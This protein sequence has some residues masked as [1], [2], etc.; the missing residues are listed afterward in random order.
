M[1]HYCASFCR[2]SQPKV[3]PSIVAAPPQKDT[4]TTEDSTSQKDESFHTPVAKESMLSASLRAGAFDANAKG[5][6]TCSMPDLR[7]LFTSSPQAEPPTADKEAAPP[8]HETNEDSSKEEED[9]S[10]EEEELVNKFVE[11]SG[12]QSREDEEGEPEEESWSSSDEEDIHQ[13]VQT[14]QSYV[15]E[16]SML[17]ILILN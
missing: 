8:N 6:L 17:S 7:S 4:P 11:E 15:D 1:F 10:E 3:S 13:L 9:E 2:H 12:E 14:L 5:L 16:S